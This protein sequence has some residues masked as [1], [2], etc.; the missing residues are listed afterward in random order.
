MA[1]MK[2]IVPAIVGH[3]TPLSL[4]YTSQPT[5][6]VEVLDLSLLLPLPVLSGVWLWNCRPW[7]YL[8]AGMSLTT[9]TMVGASGVID[10]VFEHNADPMVSLALAPLFAAVTLIGLWL[11][12]LYFHARHLEPEPALC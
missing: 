10:F 1:W 3:A 5:N 9:I 2:D 4:A 7:G 11:L 8:L 6:P 12:A